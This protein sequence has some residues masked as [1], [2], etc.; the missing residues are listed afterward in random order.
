MDDKHS[1]SIVDW[2]TYGAKVKYVGSIFLGSIPG[3][4]SLSLSGFFFPYRFFL[5]VLWF[6]D[7]CF[8]KISVCEHVCLPNYMCFLHFFTGSFYLFYLV[9]VCLYIVII[10]FVVLHTYLYSNVSKKVCGFRWVRK[11]VDSRSWRR[12]NHNQ[13]ITI[14]YCIEIIKGKYKCYT[15]RWQNYGEWNPVRRHVPL[16]QVSFRTS[17]SWLVCLSTFWSWKGEHLRIPTHRAMRL[18]LLKVCKQWS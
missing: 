3:L 18:S 10:I 6:L 8:S 13:S 17:S 11:W 12:R 9:L 4:Y 16:K 5:C 2:A 1:Y 14:T 15:M 7:L